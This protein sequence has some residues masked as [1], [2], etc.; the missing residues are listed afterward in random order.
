MFSKKVPK[1]KKMFI[2]KNIII[3]ENDVQKE[4]YESSKNPN[5]IQRKYMWGSPQ[6]DKKLMGVWKMFRGLIFPIIN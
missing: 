4:V 6:I 2:V 1:Q 5:R 3:W